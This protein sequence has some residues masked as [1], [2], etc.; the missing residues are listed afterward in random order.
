MESHGGRCEVHGSELERE[1]C[2]A[3]KER[4]RGVERVWGLGSAR[5]LL[6]NLYK[7]CI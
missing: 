5:D 1:N 3:M 7:Q 6:K 2:G 4:E